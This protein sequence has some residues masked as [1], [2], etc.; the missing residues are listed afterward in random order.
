MALLR[1]AAYSA[2]DVQ[3]SARRWLKSLTPHMRKVSNEWAWSAANWTQ[4]CHPTASRRLSILT[5]H[6]LIA[7]RVLARSAAN[8]LHVCHPSA[9]CPLMSRAIECASMAIDDASCPAA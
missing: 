6:L 5:L 8:T 9:S 1:A 7:A 2:H 4:T 3:P